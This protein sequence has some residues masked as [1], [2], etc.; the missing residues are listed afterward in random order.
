M[1]ELKA[2]YG[3]KG[4]DKR[5]PMCWLEED[6]IEYVLGCSKGDK[7]FN[8]NDKRVKEWGE[9]VESYIKNKKNRSIDNIQEEQNILEE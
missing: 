5:C 6:T 4:L 9:I 2:N 7:K 8:L 1:W 3:R